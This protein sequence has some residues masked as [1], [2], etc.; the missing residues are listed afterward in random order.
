MN[1]LCATCRIENIKLIFVTETWFSDASTVNLT[2]YNV[3][4]K[5]RMRTGGG[6]A[7]YAHESLVATE[8]NDKTLRARLGSD[9]VEQVWCQLVFGKDIV[10]L[11]CI[12]RPPL[13]NRVGEE[14]ERHIKTATEINEILRAAKTAV[15]GK[16]FKGLC[17]LGDFNFPG[18][19]WF[20]DG[21]A[22]VH[23][24]EN[25]LANLAYDF[26]EITN[27]L[28]LSQCI[29]EPT[30]VNAN[31]TPTNILD[32]LLTDERDR[33]GDISMGPPLGSTDQGHKM[34]RFVLHGATMSATRFDSRQLNYYRGDYEGLSVEASSIDWWT[35]FRNLPVE[36][37]YDAFLNEYDR[38][39]KKF[40]P[41]RRPGN[42][43]KPPW[44]NKETTEILKTKRKLW[45][46]NQRTNWRCASLIKQYKAARNESDKRIK[47]SVR[48]F[49][50]RLAG[51]KKN[52]KR[53][54]SYISSKQSVKGKIESIEDN[55]G[56]TYTDTESISNIL[57]EQFSSVF[58]REQK[59]EGMPMFSDREFGS[60]VLDIID[61]DW[62]DVQK[63][64]ERLNKHKSIGG[65]GVSSYVLRECAEAFSTPLVLI[66]RRSLEE[67][68]V[69]MAWRDANVTPIFKKGSRLDPSNYRPVSLTSVVCKVL[70]SIIRYRIMH[71]LIK[72]KLIIDQQHGFVPR[73]ACVT[74]LLETVD[75]IT[76]NMHH[77][78]PTDIIFL[79]FAKA[80][81]KVSHCKLRCS[82]ACSLLD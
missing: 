18:I 47:K 59:D 21:S 46:A 38:L 62:D 81:D 69:P 3:F 66:F 54:F 35:H 17:L 33:I 82:R 44:L 43:L 39:C 26:W 34:I 22:R 11:G 16:R 29:S 57:N 60:E 42:R 64:L 71:H 23:R 20:E 77:R 53:L 15:E 8:L 63:R 27:D 14:V 80:F 68:S 4:R 36:K 51:D 79:D 76:N 1:E 61:V 45:H 9:I 32:L 31:A 41:V 13:N 25:R 74:N 52:P 6:V 19:I 73:K 24:S 49:E 28:A 67:G 7:I 12:Y 78:T 70:E 50:M 5:D 75:Y 72:N 37:A 2:G 65:D 30:F 40:I 58:V 56:M 55:N 48:A 10:L